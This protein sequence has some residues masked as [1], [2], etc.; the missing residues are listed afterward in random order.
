M[1]TSSIGTVT[2]GDLLNSGSQL[3]NERRFYLVAASISLL[4]SVVGFRNFYFG[5]HGFG[6]NPLTSD[7]KSVV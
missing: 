5:G 2:R 3:Q 4:V 1:T 6:G 7:R